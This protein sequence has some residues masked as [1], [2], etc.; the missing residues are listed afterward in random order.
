[1][2]MPD[3]KRKHNLY[4]IHMFHNNITM[5]YNILKKL[6][7]NY[8]ILLNGDRTAICWV[9]NLTRVTTEPRMLAIRHS[10]KSGLSGLLIHAYFRPDK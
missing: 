5:K 10:S 6:L 9:M 3:E 4:V 2:Y 1:M 7:R 8:W